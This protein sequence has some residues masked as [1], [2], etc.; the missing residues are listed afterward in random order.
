MQDHDLRVSGKSPLRRRIFGSALSA[1]V[2]WFV[3]NFFLFVWAFMMR[4]KNRSYPPIPDEWLVGPAFLSVYSAAF[5]FAIWMVALLPLYLF[6]PRRSFLWRWPVCTGCGALAGALIMFA[7]YGPN[8]PDSSSTLMI[9][10]AS[11]MGA[12]ICLFGALT[13]ERFQGAPPPTKIP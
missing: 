6:V 5:V 4:S 12:I 13:V 8:S 2:G 11:M 3:L 1:F 9:L 10:L 7:F